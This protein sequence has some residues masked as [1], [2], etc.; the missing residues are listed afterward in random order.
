[1]TDEERDRAI[2][3]L[4]REVSDAASYAHKAMW[5][6]MIAACCGVIL[7]LRAGGFL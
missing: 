3:W 4:K 2:E 7:I 5:F 6:S 1:M